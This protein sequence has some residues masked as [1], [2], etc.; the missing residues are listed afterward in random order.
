V[1]DVIVIG[2]GLAGLT[3]ASLLAKRGLQVLVIDKSYNPGGA[4]GTFKRGDVIF[5]QGS[6]MLYGFGERGFNAHAF[7]FDCLQEPIDMVKHELLYCVNFRGHRVKFWPDVDKFVEEL[8]GVF[9]SQRAH[10]QRFYRDLRVIYQHVMVENPAYTTPD[11]TPPMQAMASVLRHPGSYIRFLSYLNRSARSLLEQYFTDPEIFKFFDKLTST[12]CYTTLAE[13]PAVLAAVMFIDNHVGGSYYPAGSTVFLPGKL[14]KVIEE[15]GGEMLL[16][17]EVVRILFKDGKPAGVALG[18]GRE[19]YAANLIYSGTVRNLYGKLIEA[20]YATPAKVAW[21]ANQVLSYPSVVLYA[22][23]ER[24]GIPDDTAPIEMLI[25][26]PDQLDEG[27][28]TVYIPSIDDHTLCDPDTHVVIAI[29]PTFERWD[30]SDDTAY[31]SQKVREQQR[32]IGVLERRFPG[33]SGRVR[34]A[35]IAT[36]CTIERYTLKDGGSVAGPKQMLGQHMLRRQH[37][38]T[39]WDTLYCCGEATV[40]G[41]GTPAVTTSGISAANALLKKLGMAPYVHRRGM[42]NYVRI[43]QPP[44][45]H[46]DLYSD[47]PDDLRTIRQKAAMCQYCEHPTCSGDLDI[48]G[49]MRRVTVGNLVGAKR[50]ANGFQ[51]R[52]TPE[53]AQTALAECE[54]RCI[55]R[56]ADKAPVAIVDIYRYLLNQH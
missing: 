15:H 20:E 43:L 52:F 8:A 48:R 1:A 37:T 42:R 55:R 54:A 33:I 30:R 45:T 56:N 11:E 27:E 14:E 25:G 10:L 7:V 35:E 17:Q 12:Y 44:V 41:T 2:A 38:R 46:N 49:M 40:L 18:D 3:A 6:S 51:T 23:V 21:A 5:D 32:L 47:D 53:G 31:Q 4:C 28:V 9:P 39:R 26:N 24:D 13:S 36:P 22:S 19:I 16:E 29:G 34:Y 50:L